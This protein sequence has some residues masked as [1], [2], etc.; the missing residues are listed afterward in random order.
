ME[1]TYT[2]NGIWPT[3]LVKTEL[4]TRKKHVIWTL[5]TQ[6]QT[7]TCMESLVCISW[8][9][10]VE[11]HIPAVAFVTHPVIADEITVNKV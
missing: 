3:A 1:R 6:L 9:Q 4:R 11:D 10:H 7:E 8:R 5:G 2:K